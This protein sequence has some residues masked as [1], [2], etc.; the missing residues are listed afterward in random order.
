MFGGYTGVQAMPGVEG[1]VSVPRWDAGKD[2]EVTSRLMLFDARCT[3]LTG[4]L[5]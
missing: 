3:I 1:T 2:K 4:F 5:A